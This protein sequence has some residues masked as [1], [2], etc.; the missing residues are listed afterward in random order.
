[1]RDLWQRIEVLM[2]VSCPSRYARLPGPASPAEIGDAENV[3]GIQ[4]PGEL[5]DLLAI[6]NGP[7]DAGVSGLIETYCLCSTQEVAKHWQ[8]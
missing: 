2:K 6:H 7:G 5:R 3:I 8:F 4:L 1:M